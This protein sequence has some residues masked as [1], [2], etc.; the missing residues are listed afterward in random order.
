MQLP[1]LFLAERGIAQ[2]PGFA[3][4]PTQLRDASG[5]EHSVFSR[6]DIESVRTLFPFDTTSHEHIITMSESLQLFIAGFP[7]SDDRRLMGEAISRG[8]P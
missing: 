6:F 3:C 2:A 8:L 1:P 5:C 4:L 7:R